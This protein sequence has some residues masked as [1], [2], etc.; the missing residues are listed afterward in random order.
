MIKQGKKNIITDEEL[1]ITH[2]NQGMKQYGLICVT[3]MIIGILVVTG[4]VIVDQ[5]TSSILA[6]PFEIQQAHTTPVN[7]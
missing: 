5:L 4:I 1:E 7:N 6:D 2:I 3:L